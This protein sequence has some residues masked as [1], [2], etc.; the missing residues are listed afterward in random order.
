MERARH[1]FSLLGR[2]GLSVKSHSAPVLQFVGPLR[3]VV[4]RFAYS[5]LVLVSLAIIVVGKADASLVERARG[6]VADVMAPILSVLSRPVGTVSGAVDRFQAMVRLYQDNEQLRTENAA[7]L[8]WQQVARHLDSENQEL[9]TLLNY[10]PENAGW[11]VTAEVIGTSG[12]A[13]SRNMLIDRGRAD[14]VAKGQAVVSGTGLVGRVAEV[15]ER[16]ARVLLLTDLNSRIPVAFESTHERAILAGD[17]SDRPQ[18]IY[19]PAH[20]KVAIGDKLLTSGDGGVFPPGLEVGIVAA[21]EGGIRIEPVADL[22]R[23]DYL[24]IVDFGLGGVLPQSA[25]PTPKIPTRRAPPDL[26]A[27]P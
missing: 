21:I 3:S 8:Q 14:G 26:A 9:R 16:A 7:L 20:A 6:A 27:K 2:G 17:N 10:R 4:Q 23:I 25:V 15:G 19:L 11:F 1:P 12:G 13:Y 24:R 5:S 22:A 18:L